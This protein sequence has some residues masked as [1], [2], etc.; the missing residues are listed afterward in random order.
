[1]SFTPLLP[2]A[3]D[4]ALEYGRDY[5]I[6]KN[7]TLSYVFNRATRKMVTN[8]GF[9]H[10]SQEFVYSLTSLIL[11]WVTNEQGEE[12]LLDENGHIYYEPN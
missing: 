4:S 11:F 9:A 1:M 6:L 10:V 2:L 12:F 8:I 3:Y 5:L 7:G